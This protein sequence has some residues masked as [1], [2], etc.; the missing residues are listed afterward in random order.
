[1]S[2]PASPHSEYEMTRQL[3]R[4]SRRAGAIHSHRPCTPG[5]TINGGPAP[6][7]S[8]GQ[9]I[10]A[11]EAVAA[12]SL[13]HGFSFEWTGTALQEKAAAGQTGPIL[14]LAYLHLVAL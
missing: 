11:M 7:Y 3:P 13:P 5:M 2:D 6:G 9:A 14:G 12:A 8:S 4:S 10:T 1:M